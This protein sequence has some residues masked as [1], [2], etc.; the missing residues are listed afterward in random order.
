MYWRIARSWQHAAG[1]LAVVPLA[2]FGLAFVRRWSYWLRSFALGDFASSGA[3]DIAVLLANTLGFLV[4]ALVARHHAPILEHG[5]VVPASTALLVAGSA[6]VLFEG[7]PVWLAAAG[8]V[9]ASLG[10]AV[11]FLLWLEL[12]GSLPLT[13]MMAAYF[14]SMLLSAALIAFMGGYDRDLAPFIVLVLPL[15]SGSC[16]TAAY[17]A[18]PEQALPQSGG[19]PVVDV[20]FAKLLVWVAV[21]GLAFGA[22]EGSTAMAT[23]GA[24]SLIGRALLSGVMFA[25]VWLFPRRFTLATV[26]RVTLPVMVLGVVLVFFLD[27]VPAVS[28]AFLS[29]GLDGY[30]ALSLIVCSGVALHYRTSPVFW[31]GLAFAVETVAIQL[32]RVGYQGLVMQL[33]V[34][35]AAVGAFFIVALVVATLFLF[36]ESDLMASY[37]ERAL[38]SVR[39]GD[40]MA[41][42]LAAFCSD[43]GLTDKEASVFLLMARG[44]SVKDIASELY[45]A[46]STVRVHASK[47]YQ[48]LS[49]RGREE[50]DGL[51]R[52]VIGAEVTRG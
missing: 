37:S 21:F 51:L 44:M 48:K 39:E 28:Q 14:G 27:S 12:Y 29:A 52:E 18:V 34:S 16:L 47:I 46:P 19:T 45:L 30:Q 49:V 38:R 9:L 8:S 42:E 41:R 23:S 11:M 25:G 36:R 2:L 5:W 24:S 22:A 32:G 4:V 20:G 43:H 7:A 50:F 10:F 1:G 3:Y 35:P 6:P 40:Q 31:C 26:Y 13:K 17:L 15:L 33:G